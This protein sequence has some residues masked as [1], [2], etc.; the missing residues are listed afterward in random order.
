MDLRSYDQLTVAERVNALRDARSEGIDFAQLDED[1]PFDGEDL[2]THLEPRVFFF[3]VIEPAWDGGLLDDETYAHWDR[4]LREE[5]SDA[6]PRVKTWIEAVIAEYR[7]LA[8]LCELCNQPSVDC[9]CELSFEDIADREPLGGGQ[10]P[11]EAIA[12][13]SG[14]VL[15]VRETHE[16]HDHA[17]EDNDSCAGG[18]LI[19]TIEKAYAPTIEWLWSYDDGSLTRR[20]R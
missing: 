4:E 19:I 12:E 7:A 10:T 16:R 2:V 17:E 18:D 15:A 14:E 5:N 9:A 6:D 20:E 11:A 13:L 8:D 3:A 1:G